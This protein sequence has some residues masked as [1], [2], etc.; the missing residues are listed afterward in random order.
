MC[1]IN[2]HPMMC[3]PFF[4]FILFENVDI[5]KRKKYFEIIKKYIRSL[6]NLYPIIKICLSKP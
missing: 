3:Q 2:V 4:K 1:V 5:N 6:E